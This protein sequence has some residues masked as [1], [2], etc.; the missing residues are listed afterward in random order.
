MDDDS[1]V[2]PTN[3]VWTKIRYFLVKKNDELYMGYTK[4]SRRNGCCDTGAGIYSHKKKLGIFCKF[5]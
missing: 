1:P 4:Q 5:T 2:E 3:R